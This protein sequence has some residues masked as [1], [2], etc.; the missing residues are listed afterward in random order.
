[1]T[2]FARAKRLAL[3]PVGSAYALAGLARASSLFDRYAA[4]A[5]RNGLDQLH[6]VLSFDCDTPEDAEVTGGLHRRLVDLGAKPVY[7]VPGELLERSPET[8]AAIAADG[9][10]FLNHGYTEHVFVDP[11]TQRYASCFFYDELP[12]EA[13]RNDIVR[14]GRAVEAVTGSRPTGFRVP[15]FGTFQRPDQLRFLREVLVEEGYRYSSSTTPVFGFRRGPAH[16]ADGIVEFPVS[17][18]RSRP[19]TILDTWGCFEAPDRSRTADDYFVEGRA[20][21]E[22]LAGRGVGILNFYG[23]PIHVHDEPAFFRTVES[24]LDVAAPI[25]YA[26]LLERLP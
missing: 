5:R 9:Y 17:G 22:A 26:D 19:L 7:A 3:D 2:S 25:S 8:Y 20:T 21:A 18:M 15:H 12:R 13:V 10:E 1:M 16:R 4:L 14:G 24:W 23:D 6:L 11:D